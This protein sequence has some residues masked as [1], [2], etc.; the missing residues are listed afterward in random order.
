MNPLV[1]PDVAADLRDR[2]TNRTS[3]MNDDGFDKFASRYTEI[4]DRNV[5][6]SGSG[7]HYFD[8]Y[9][10]RCLKNGVI[11]AEDSLD[12]LD[13]GCG[14]GD[15]SFLMAKAFPNSRVFGFDVSQKCIEAARQKYPHEDNLVFLNQRGNENYDLICA[16]NVFHHVPENERTE[17]LWSLKRALKP[18][19]RI[20]IFEHNP[21][22][23]VTR[24]AV[25]T[26]EFDVGVKL[27]SR[28]TFIKSAQKAGLTT[29]IKR[30]VVFFPQFAETLRTL[31]P[32]LWS[33][34]LG[35]QYMVVLTVRR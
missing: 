19:G 18:D 25:K 17:L 10:L 16:V 9:K 5:R 27:I 26:C 22:N 6:F 23:L 35:A 30:Y 31:E 28:R 21:W 11:S 15:L 32:M 4:L 2:A 24:Y 13:F 12:V 7:R 20:V 33:L 14:T 3:G 34:P 1:A 8:E 29:L